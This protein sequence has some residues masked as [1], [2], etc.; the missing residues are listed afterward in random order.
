M[1]E[2]EIEEVL[3]IRMKLYEKY[4]DYSLRAL[5]DELEVSVVFNDFDSVEVIKHIILEDK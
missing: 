2:K 5:L 1:K 3:E 4:M